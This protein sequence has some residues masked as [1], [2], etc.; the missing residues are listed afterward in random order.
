MLKS[1]NFSSK[2]P[3]HLALIYKNYDCALALVDSGC[4][5]LAKE[6]IFGN[7]PLAYAFE[8]EATRKLIEVLSRL[9][10]K[11]AETYKTMFGCSAMHELSR[12]RGGNLEEVFKL[13]APAGQGIEVTHEDGEIPLLTAVSRNNTAVFKILVSAG[14]SLTARSAT[15]SSIL[16]YA[17]HVGDAD[18]LRS[19]L[20][21]EISLDIELRNSAG[22]TALDTF[23]YC[24]LADADLFPSHWRRPSNEEQYLFKELLRTVRDRYLNEEI[25]QLD[26][27]IRFECDNI[28]QAREQLDSI[29][30]EKAK[31]HKSDEAKT[32]WVIKDVQLRQGMKDAA[33]EALN[34]IVVV[35][36]ETMCESPFTQPSVADRKK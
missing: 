18:L 2:T 35:H 12:L 23:R 8:E 6:N 29:M 34:D 21:A 20:E 33:V 4:D 27:A 19:L 17:A 26:G 1:R 14:A 30:M 24:L 25:R 15:R 9:L 22:H 16:H 10:P 7:V 36:R 3:L 11:T 5:I 28:D 32:I 13:L 31:Y